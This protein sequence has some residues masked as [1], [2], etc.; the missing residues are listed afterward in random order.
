MDKKSKQIFEENG[1][2][3]MNEV[4]QRYEIAKTDLKK[5]GS[6]E[7]FVFEYEKDNQKR[8]LKITHNLHRTIDQVKGELE[9]VNFL[10]ENGVS[11]PPVIRSKNGELVE[12]ISLEYSYFLVYAFEK[13]RGS[14]PERNLWSDVLFES[15]GKVMGRMHALA[16][17]YQPSEMAVKRFHWYE[18]PSLRVEQY[19]PAS[20]PK[21]IEMC[22]RLKNKLLT[23]TADM[24]AYGL[25]HSDFHHSNFYVDSD[26][27][28]VFDF[29]DC[30]YN[31]FAFDIA[32][33]LFY[34]LRD[35]GVDPNDKS[36]AR[37]FMDCF[38]S[39]YKQE[40]IIDTSC[41]IRIPDFLKLREMDLYTIVHAEEAFNLNGWCQRFMEGRQSRIE[42]DIPII[43]I[44]FSAFG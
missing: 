15:W 20:Q 26:E 24:D 39:G 38:M 9:W 33:P 11:V 22:N 8:I 29:D 25:I 4:A 40:N 17:R 41:L 19:I 34:V 37:H 44:D 23:F 10:A 12:L 14:L 3:I 18:D 21:V 35:A 27:I 36:F 31:W 43:D 28:T 32:I 16:K 1:D 2:Y 42:N 13:A 6:F 7:S 30:H 5:L